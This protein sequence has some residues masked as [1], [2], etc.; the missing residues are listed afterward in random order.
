MGKRHVYVSAWS[1]RLPQR[2]HCPAAYPLHVKLADWAI[3]KSKQIVAWPSQC[4]SNFLKERPRHRRAQVQKGPHVKHAMRHAD[5][6]C[7]EFILVLELL[8]WQVQTGKTGS[9][10][11]EPRVYRNTQITRLG[12][13]VC[14][15]AGE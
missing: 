11:A 10:A 9:S 2:E 1:T 13:A 5:G 4:G 8:I 6:F 12:P 14:Y 7:D 3:L 15:P